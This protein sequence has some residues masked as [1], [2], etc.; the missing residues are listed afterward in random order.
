M[1]TFFELSRSR[2]LIGDDAQ[3]QLARLRKS[4][5]LDF[6]QEASFALPSSGHAENQN[7]GF[8]A[9][10]SLSGGSYPC[11]ESHCRLQRAD[12]L[13][14]LAALYA[15]HVVIRNPF[16]SYYAT[17]DLDSLRHRLAGDMAVLSRL[18]PLI[19]S[20]IVSVTP[21]AIAMCRS[22]SRQFERERQ[23]LT[24]A[25]DKAGDEI[26]SRYGHRISVRR[27][28]KTGSFAIRGPEEIV[29]HGSRFLRPGKRSDL[30]GRLTSKR[31]ML[32][33]RHLI[34]PALSD[35]YLHHIHS[36]HSRFNYLTDHELDLTVIRAVG[37]PAIE[38]IQ[39]AI[40]R[41]L[42][43]SLPVLTNID[44]P[45]L[46]R[47]RESEG[48][49]F[50]VYR[51]RLSEVLR[52]V[53]LSSASAIQDAFA[54]HIQ[55]ELDRM[56][57]AAANA[58]KLVKRSAANQVGVASAA[59]SIGLLVGTVEPA[60]GAVIAALG[61]AQGLGSLAQRTL[62]LLQEPPVVRDNSF[63]FLWKLRRQNR[64]PRVEMKVRD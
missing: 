35:V 34:Q 1:D 53:D 51:N 56:D 64:R 46:L 11:G 37:G 48:E 43:H 5:L 16:T 3:T 45:S 14:T 42:A 44:V 4:K 39:Q 21:P 59:V 6:V 61:G 23:R 62:D 2:G 7:F 30:S 15:D 60:I 9:N 27:D 8:L 22:C 12:R 55:P 40:A 36:R 13:A 17:S 32:A 18:E 57:L 29:V 20:R 49:A 63:Y 58:R 31:R 24:T 26:L 50:A 47:L 28:I 19:N 38:P 25:I 10:T 52:T 54:S 33:L 41:G